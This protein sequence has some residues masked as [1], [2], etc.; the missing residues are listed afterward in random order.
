MTNDNAD[1]GTAD[2]PQG[3]HLPSRLRGFQTELAALLEALPDLLFEVDLDGRI[4]GYHAPNDDL[5]AA[6]PELFMGKLLSDVLPAAVNQ[7]CM[8]AIEEAVENGSC[9]GYTYYLQLPMGETWF[10]LSA[11]AVKREV[12]VG[13]RVVLLTRDVTRRRLAE[14]ALTASRDLLVHLAENVP[15][16]IYQYR[17][18]P[19][20][21]S[22]FPYSSRGLNE[23]YEVTPEEAL[24]D[25]ALVFERLHPDDLDRVARLIQE[26]A[27]SLGM[28]RCEFRVVLPRQGLRWRKSQARPERMPDGG[29]L[30]H[31][32]IYDITETKIAEEAG[33]RTTADL[34]ESNSR[35]SRFNEIA[36]EREVRMIELKREVNGLCAQ[37]GQPPRHRV[38]EV[39]VAP[40]TALP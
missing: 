1:R 37:L 36:V 22:A 13:Q 38:V 7:V 34:H 24:K 33:Q 35:L 31:G 32:T 19:D 3:E 39:V 6:P 28:F 16:V 21:H 9:A 23:I 17:L 15:G 29:T 2:E 25:A 30:W 27:D 10:E 40:P 4:F 18:Y 26:S 20:G 12:S 14:E 8:R 11:A 5:L